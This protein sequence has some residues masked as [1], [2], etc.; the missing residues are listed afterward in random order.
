MLATEA[1]LRKKSKSK[2]SWFYFVTWPGLGDQKIGKKI[3]PSVIVGGKSNGVKLL[4][5]ML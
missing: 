3:V 5:S 4:V 1:N 2:R